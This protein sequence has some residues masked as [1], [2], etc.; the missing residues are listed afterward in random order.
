M[1]FEKFAL[2]LQ[3]LCKRF[4]L[5]D[6]LLRTVYE[7]NESELQWVHSSSQ[8]VQRVRSVVHEIEFRQ[9]TNCSPPH[10]IDLASELERLGVD[11]IDVGGGYGEDDAVGLRDV[12]GDEVARLF[13]DIG[14]LIANGH[15]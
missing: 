3:S 6:V 1:V 8:D 11:E 4:V 5:L 2:T 7:S 13:L 10:R 12:L 14:G 9:D 15:L